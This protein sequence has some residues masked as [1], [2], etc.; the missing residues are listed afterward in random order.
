MAATVC[1]PVRIRVG[2]TEEC[3]VGSI[4]LDEGDDIFQAVAAFYRALADEI[5]RRPS[6][7]PT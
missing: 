4:E 1:V 7:W 2:D 5:E 6:W 3:H